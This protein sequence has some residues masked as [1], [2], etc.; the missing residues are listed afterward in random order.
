M[1]R[2]QYRPTYIKQWRERL[3]ITQEKLAERVGLSDGYISLLETGSR[4][5]TQDSLERSPTN[6]AVR[7]ANCWTSIRRA[8][9]RSWHI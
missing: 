2:K 4:G 5:Y 7:R 6:W 3:G 1:A 9:P 8:T